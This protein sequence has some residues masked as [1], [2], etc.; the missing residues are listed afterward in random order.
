MSTE[1]PEGSKSYLWLTAVGLALY[2]V[3]LA[4]VTG[5]IGF[6]GDDWW[7]LAGPY[8]HSFLT[9]WFSTL[10]SSCDR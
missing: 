8:W 4:A 9:L 6:N 5:D 2:C 10:R 1:Q 3:V 7:V